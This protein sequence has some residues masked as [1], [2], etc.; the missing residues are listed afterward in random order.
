MAIAVKQTNFTEVKR[1]LLQIGYKFIY[2]IAG[3]FAAY[4]LATYAWYICLGNDRKKVR[5]GK[6][7]MIRQVCETISLYNP[8]SIIAGDL[9]KMQFLKPYHISAQVALN[10]VTISRITTILSQ[11][12]LFLLSSLWLL[13]SPTGDQMGA[14]IKST[15]I[16]LLIG[17]LIA[18]IGLIYWLNSNHMTPFKPSFSP[19]SSLWTK[20]KQKIKLIL[21]GMKT[22]YR[23]EKKAFW[24]SYALN[25]AHW[26]IGSMEFFLILHFLGFKITIMHGLLLD[27]STMVFKSFG[28]FIPGQ[29]GIE[30]L[31]N[32]IALGVIGL[33]A[34]SIW[35]TVSIFRRLRQFL[36]AVVGIIGYLFLKRKFSHASIN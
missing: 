6:L 14:T 17:I 11:V 26:I 1:E 31:G 3:T 30:E 20:S 9:L 25:V 4:L 15:F 24:N 5:F 18:K 19:T 10:S 33:Q 2:S 22:F 34:S 28:S 27:M 13:L 29:I 16:V 21:L 23:K 35:I 7:F 36:W 8:T 12:L 32:K